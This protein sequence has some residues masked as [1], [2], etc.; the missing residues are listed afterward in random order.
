MENQPY[1]NQA[2]LNLRGWNLPHGVTQVFQIIGLYEETK[3]LEEAS[4]TM[5]FAK[6]TQ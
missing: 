1:I 3:K 4:I 2:E 5:A 6:S